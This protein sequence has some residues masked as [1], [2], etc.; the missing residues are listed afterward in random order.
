MDGNKFYWVSWYQTTEDYRPLTYPPN[1]GV[2]SWHCTGHR[3]HDG[4]ATLVAMVK[5]EN[6]EQAKAVIVVDWPEASDWRF[7]DGSE[8]LKRP[9]NRFPLQG[10]MEKRYSEQLSQQK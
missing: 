7:C 5:A 6:E 8:K 9:N 1:A 3:D 10:W 4:A 2:L